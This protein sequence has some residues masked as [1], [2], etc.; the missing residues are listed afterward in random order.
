MSNANALSVTYLTL[1]AVQRRRPDITGGGMLP[2]RMKP[3]LPITT[4]LCPPI[5]YGTVQFTHPMFSDPH[6]P[7]QRENAVI[8]SESFTVPS[9]L[10]LSEETPAP[11]S[12]ARAR[13]AW[14]G[15]D[16]RVRGSI[17]ALAGTA[18]LLA[19]AFLGG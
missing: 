14:L 4:S 15:V 10:P 19:S 11:V 17:F 18:T 6:L 12:G 5:P 8:R 13:Y 16:G 7:A 9:T 2:D 3:P 1:C